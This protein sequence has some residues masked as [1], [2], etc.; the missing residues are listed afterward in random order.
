MEKKENIPDHI[1][2]E[3]NKLLNSLYFPI[4]FIL[5]LWFI[6]FLE[7]IL[8]YNF[9]DFGIYPLKLSGL[10]G[11]LFS[12]F[13]HGSFLHLFNNS[14]PVLVLGTALFYFYRDVA[15]KIIILSWLISGFWVWFMA[16]PAYHIGA[17]GLIY[18][19]ASF[20][21]FSGII[22]KNKN[23]LAISLL[24]TFLYGSLIWGIF[25]IEEKISWEGH[26][27][28]GIAGFILSI[29][30]K[31][32]GPVKKEPEWYDE[33]EDNEENEENENSSKQNNV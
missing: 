30:F 13:I 12:P 32:Y 15:Y 29:Y 28:G 5:I 16:R 26:L 8:D 9:T 21:F 3:K 20:L 24:V 4:V 23:L 1:Q 7:T 18:A 17:S 25:P 19:W 11:I 2:I 33:D 27:M 14:V 22:R 6:K 10:K 31:D